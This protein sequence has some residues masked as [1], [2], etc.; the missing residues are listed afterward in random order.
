MQ[1]VI[2]AAGSGKRMKSLTESK[3]KSLLEIGNGETFLSKIC[4][5]INEYDISKAVIVTGYRPESIVDT[6]N[7]F[8]F[9][10]EVVHNER[11][12]EDVNIYSLKLALDRLSNK[13]NFSRKLDC[14]T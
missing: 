1:I 2:L 10:F 14:N 12:E 11:Y 4:H 13:E 5:Q 8:Q 7:Q 3:H 6:L 9:N